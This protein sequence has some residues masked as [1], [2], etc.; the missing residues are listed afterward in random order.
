MA[1]ACCEETPLYGPTPEFLAYR[2]DPMAET[3]RAV[4]AL[5][6]DLRYAQRYA[7]FHRNMVYGDQ[8]VYGYL[9]GRFQR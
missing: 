6:S 1:N 8:P 7:D 3:Q 5:A 9:R 4:E 2:A